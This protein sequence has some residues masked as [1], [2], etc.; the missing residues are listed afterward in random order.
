MVTGFMSLEIDSIAGN[1][2]F[3][4]QVLAL[5]WVKQN[6]ESFGGDSNQITVFGQ[7]AGGGSISLLL[8][9]PMVKTLLF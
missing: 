9:S 8:M 6:I 7:S 3:M 5:K 1:M 2:G 4:D